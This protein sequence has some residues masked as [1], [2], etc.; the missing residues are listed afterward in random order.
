MAQ[1]CSPL[2]PS[3][4]RSIMFDMPKRNRHREKLKSGEPP[5]PV[6]TGPAPAQ[7]PKPAPTAPKPPKTAKPPPRVATPPLDPEK[8]R[9]KDRLKRK[10][11]EERNVKP[12]I[13]AALEALAARWPAAFPRDR[14]TLR[15]W[16]IGLHN[17]IDEKSLGISR[18]VLRLALKRVT[19][20]EE[21]LTALASGGPR[22]DLEGNPRGEVTEEARADAVTRLA[23]LRANKQA[24]EPAERTEAR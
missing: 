6:H 2:I 4:H 10:R 18:Q 22:I 5:A 1:P 8:R 16:A 14:S 13:P 20:S 15:P 3:P 12:H 11:Y 7:P 19:R 9:E 21:Y 24:P 17:D 23:E